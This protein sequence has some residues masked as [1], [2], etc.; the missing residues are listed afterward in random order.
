MTGLAGKKFLNTK[1]V[2]ALL[3]VNEK[4]I[5]SLIHQKGLPATKITG[6][7]LFPRRLVEE[8]LE[9]NLLNYKKTEMSA[10]SD[11]GRLLIAGSDDPLFQQVMSLY[12]SVSE[13]TTVFFANIG[14]MG[15]LKSLRRGLCHIGICHLLQDD[16]QDYNFEFAH[17]ELDVSPVFINFSRREQGLVIQKGNPK[18]IYSISD[19]AQPNVT[20][21][22]R[23]LGTGT[24]L[25]LDYEIGRS[26]ITTAQIGGYENELSKH[27][28]V[29]LAVLSGRADA[30]PAIKAVAGLLDLDFI[31]LRWERFDLL[32]DPERFFDHAVQRFLAILQDEAFYRLADSFTGYDLSSCGK[33]IFPDNF[34]NEV[35]E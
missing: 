11:D 20:I 8:W 2:A 25:L 5:Y 14:S 23:P 12:H 32:V 18:K 22:N 35:S 15:G 31:S 10:S 6:K 21:M 24:R 28:D 30:A 16:D 9:T 29:G 13:E 3:D 7:W 33:V 4:I 17:K 34:N 19:L 1:D 27:L 26:D